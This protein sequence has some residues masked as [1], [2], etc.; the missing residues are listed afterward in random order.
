[1]LGLMRHFSGSVLPAVTAHVLFD[2]LVY[3]DWAQA[4][5]WVWG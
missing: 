4:P 2:I 1:M 5:W 3:G